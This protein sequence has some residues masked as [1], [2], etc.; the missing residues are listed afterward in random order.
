[1]ANRLSG[2]RRADAESACA[3]RIE[4]GGAGDVLR[5]DGR[6]DAGAVARCWNDIVPQA[7]PELLVDASGLADLDGAGMALL[8]TLRRAGAKLEGLAPRFEELLGLVPLDALTRDSGDCRRCGLA[9]RVGRSAGSASRDLGTLVSFVGEC[10]LALWQAVRHPRSVRRRDVLDAM[11]AVGVDSMPIL[12]LIGFLMGLIMSFQSAVSL[13]RFGA[14]IF[15]PNMLG[16]VMFR[17]MGGLITAILLAAR[18]GSAFAAEIGTMKVNEE[19]DALVTMGLSPMRFLVAPKVIA[20]VLMVPL[21]TLFFNFASLAGGA[22]V[23]LS[24]GFPL[25]T[26]T[27][28]VFANTTGM[29]VGGGLLKAL[30]FSVLVAGAGCMRGMGTG[31]GAGAVGRSTTGAVVSGIILIAV[32]DGLFAVAFYLLGI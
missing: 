9:E 29:D 6:L 31:A 2:Q 14:V 13:V 11:T 26:F 15:V 17:E 23:M 1:M 28:R 27:G 5:L 18:S 22:L 8:L 10:G 7:G 21:M 4:R 16:L 12:L 19:L 20:S 3:A 32:A 25:A 24:M 30:V